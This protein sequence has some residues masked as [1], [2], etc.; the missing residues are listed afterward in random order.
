M[1]PIEKKKWQPSYA[2][3]WFLLLESI[4]SNL[5][6]FRAALLWAGMDSLIRADNG[7]ATNNLNIIIWHNYFWKDRP[8]TSSPENSYILLKSSLIPI[9][10]TL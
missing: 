5:S 10:C 3:C 7:Y 1:I 4:K 9:P 8:S 2:D 6:I